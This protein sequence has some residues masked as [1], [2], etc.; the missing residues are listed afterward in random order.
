MIWY[1]VIRTMPEG[2]EVYKLRTYEEALKVYTAFDNPDYD[3]YWIEVDSESE[4]FF[5]E[6]ED[7]LSDYDC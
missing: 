2:S 1:E 6:V 4:Y 7:V 5:D 3:T